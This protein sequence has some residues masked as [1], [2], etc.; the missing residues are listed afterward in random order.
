MGDLILTCTSGKSRNH[1]AGLKIGRGVNPKEL[2]ESDETIEGLLTVK[3]VY[4]IAKAKNIEL[5]IMEMVYKI[6]YEGLKPKEGFK[7]L[8]QLELS[9]EEGD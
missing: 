2:I 8:M 4:K 7:Q 5:P 9:S 1:Q 6:V 3:A